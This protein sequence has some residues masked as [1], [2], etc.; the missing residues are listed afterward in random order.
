MTYVKHISGFSNAMDWRPVE[1]VDLLP[2][3]CCSLCNVVPKET[4]I[5]E[6]S[7][8]LCNQCYQAVLQGNRQC[9]LDGGT[10][11]EEEVQ[12]FTFKP[13]HL[14][15][16]KLRCCNSGHGCDFVGNL[17]DITTHFLNDCEFHVVSCNRCHATVQRRDIVSHCSEQRCQTASS[18][19]EGSQVSTDKNN[20]ETKIDE[21]LETVMQRLCAIDTQ[22]NNHTIGI[23]GAKLVLDKVLEQQGRTAAHMTHVAAGIM[24]L[25]RNCTELQV[26][27]HSSTQ[28][29]EEF[30]ERFFRMDNKLDAVK[31]IVKFGTNE[32]WCHFRDFEMFIRE[33]ESKEEACRSTDAF[34]L[35]GYSAKLNMMLQHQCDG[36]YLG[37]YLSIGE[38]SND[39]LKWPLLNPHYYILLH[40]SDRLKSIEKSYDYTEDYRSSGVP[41]N[42]MRPTSTANPAFG[43]LEFCRLGEIRDGGF[44]V[45][46]AV[47]IGVVLGVH[48]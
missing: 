3:R 14:K 28:K 27:S 45:D 40:P 44:I 37:L 8:A 38:S 23:D 35:C 42:R 13:S 36:M 5:L 21:S 2:A 29:I 31:Y 46:D 41:V 19:V 20:I 15:K 12:E 11:Q 22:V 33:G 26:A 1:F 10:I 43:D 6:C 17:E 32:V 18:S 30:V 16:Q 39:L 25:Q 24:S 48:V 4:F 34:L 9:P 47:C 7:H